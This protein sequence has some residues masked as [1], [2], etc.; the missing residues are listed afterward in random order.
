MN[1]NAKIKSTMLGYED[2]GI[3]TCYIQLEQECT[4]QAFGGYRLDAPKNADSYMGTFWI[5]RVLKTVG[6]QKWE[7]LVGK[8]IRVDGEEFGEIRGIGHITDNKWFYPRR[9]IDERFKK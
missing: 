3:M 8:Y 1:G 5:E 9:E 4:G 2:H 7:D 6:V